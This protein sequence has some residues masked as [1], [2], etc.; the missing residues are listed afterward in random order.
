[1][2]GKKTDQLSAEELDGVQG[3]ALARPTQN[4]EV[5]NEDE[6]IRTRKPKNWMEVVNEDEFASTA[7][8][9][10]NI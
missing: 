7:G 9:S 4:M 2:S 1:M 5:V 8:G 10:P 3:G 6:F